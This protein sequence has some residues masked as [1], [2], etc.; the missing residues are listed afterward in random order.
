MVTGPTSAVAGAGQTI[1]VTVLLNGNP[2]PGYR[3]TVGLT[4][5]DAQATLPT[6]YTFT[7]ADQGAHSFA[8]TLRTS[9]SQK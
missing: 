7:K 9:G 4:S 2:N 5:T 3:G 1:T 6:S 8:V